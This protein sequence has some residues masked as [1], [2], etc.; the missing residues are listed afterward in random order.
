MHTYRNW[1]WLRLHDLLLV[2]NFNAFRGLIGENASERDDR[3]REKK[4]EREQT[5]MDK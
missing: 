5:A 1:W 3:Q 4:R 2:M